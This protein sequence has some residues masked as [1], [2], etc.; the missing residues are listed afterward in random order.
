M[1]YKHVSST[2]HF[3]Y[4][5]KEKN[6]YSACVRHQEMEGTGIPADPFRSNEE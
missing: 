1:S 2:K 6:G 4:V 3:E 5:D